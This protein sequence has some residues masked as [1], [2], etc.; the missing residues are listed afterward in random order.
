MKARPANPANDP[1]SGRLAAGARRRLHIRGVPTLAR[2]AQHGAHTWCT[3]SAEI[4][5]GAGRVTYFRWDLSCKN[6]SCSYVRY[7][8]RLTLHKKLNGKS[9]SSRDSPPEDVLRF[10]IFDLVRILR[11]RRSPIMHGHPSTHRRSGGQHRATPIKK[12]KIAKITGI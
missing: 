4:R 12:S 8:A 2:G 1:L 6:H 5:Y 9:C 7:A 3:H 10:S 11:P